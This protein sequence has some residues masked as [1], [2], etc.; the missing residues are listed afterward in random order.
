MEDK[1]EDIKKDKKELCSELNQPGLRRLVFAA[2]TL[3]AD[4]PNLW[5]IVSLLV[6]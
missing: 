2:S 5:E 6:K 4:T 1:N 3:P